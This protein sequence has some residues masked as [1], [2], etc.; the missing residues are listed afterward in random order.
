MDA[1]AD[2]SHPDY[3]EH[4]AWVAAMT[5]S[6]APFDPAFLDIPAVKRA[7]DEQFCLPGSGEEKATMTAG[8]GPFSG[9]SSAFWKRR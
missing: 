2:V 8:N 7:L 3:A 9:L 4:V 5:D 6:Q 1:L